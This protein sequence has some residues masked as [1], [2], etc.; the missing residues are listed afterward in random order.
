MTHRS[1]LPRLP[2]VAALL[3]LLGQ[4]V[5]YSTERPLRGTMAWLALRGSGQYS[6]AD[7]YCTRRRGEHHYDSRR[8][9]GAFDG[10]E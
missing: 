8:N 4:R 7:R 5:E 2:A 6:S 1:A 9:R 3:C 10:T